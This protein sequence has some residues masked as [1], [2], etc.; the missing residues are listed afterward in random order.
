MGNSEIAASCA[1]GTPM[2]FAIGATPGLSEMFTFTFDHQYYF[3]RSPHAECWYAYTDPNLECVDPASFAHGYFSVSDGSFVRD[4][5]DFGR[6]REQQKRDIT[7]ILVEHKSDMDLQQFDA[8]SQL[9]AHYRELGTRS[10]RY[11]DIK[12]RARE[13]GMWDPDVSVAFEQMTKADP[14]Y[15]LTREFVS[16]VLEKAR[17]VAAEERDRWLHITLMD[18]WTYDR[19]PIAESGGTF[20]DFCQREVNGL[21]VP[22]P[23]ER[24]DDT[25]H[26]VY[27]IDGL[28]G[29][30]LFAEEAYLPDFDMNLRNSRHYF[31]R[32]S[33]VV[34]IPVG[35]DGYYIL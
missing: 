29:V 20:E 10:N 6:F 1:Y 4:A 14:A 30:Y 26:R 22:K 8:Y 23:T 35:G 3:D 25:D 16:R 2:R 15:R 9:P 7:Q 18:H 32:T 21:L 33:A 11:S 5:A 24:K 34:P 31:D 19:Q 28:A 27:E 13:V 17:Q 12:G